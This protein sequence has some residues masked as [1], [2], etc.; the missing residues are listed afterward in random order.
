MK[1][2]DYEYTFPKCYMTEFLMLCKRTVV[3]TAFQCDI[4][5]H[6]M[7]PRFGDGERPRCLSDRLRTFHLQTYL[8]HPVSPVSHPLKALID[9]INLEFH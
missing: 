3:S 7:N 4:R 5:P 1:P 8:K 2:Y 9:R 6:H